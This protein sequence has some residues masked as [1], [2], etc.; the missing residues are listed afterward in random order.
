MECL[1]VHRQTRKTFRDI[2]QESRESERFMGAKEGIRGRRR[3]CEYFSPLDKLRPLWR[4]VLSGD[5]DRPLLIA[6]PSR[7]HPLSRPLQFYIDSPFGRDISLALRKPGWSQILN[8][9]DINQFNSDIS[10]WLRSYLQPTVN[11]FK[12]FLDVWCRVGIVFTHVSPS[13]PGGTTRRHTSE[14]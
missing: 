10:K 11:L 5:S 1:S 2:L 13:I 3:G 14:N 12:W 8:V 7:T 9:A 6:V 4:N